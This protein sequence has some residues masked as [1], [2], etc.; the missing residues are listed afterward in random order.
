[1]LALEAEYLALGLMNVICTLSAQ[2]IIL[3]GG[4]MSEPLLLPL[5][6]SRVQQLAAGYFDSPELRERIAEY[7][8]P[9]AL[10]DRAG[11]LGALE[12]ARLALG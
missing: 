3:G 5:I 10:G 2:R 6:R 11:V 7:V 1:M 9:P 8:V 12:L 4:V